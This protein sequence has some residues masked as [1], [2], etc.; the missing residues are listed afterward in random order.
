MDVQTHWSDYWILSCF[1]H[2]TISCNKVSRMGLR[3]WW[4]IDILSQR[5]FTR[6]CGAGYG[7]VGQTRDSLLH[8]DMM[9]LC[10]FSYF[11]HD[12]TWERIYKYMF[13]AMS[14]RWV[15]EWDTE[16]FNSH[17]WPRQN[18]SLQYQ[19]N[20][21]QRS[22]ENKEKYK[23]GDKLINSPNKHHENCMADSKENYWWDLGSERVKALKP[24]S[25]FCTFSFVLRRRICLTTKAF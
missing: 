11:H 24:P 14:L 21:K 16:P 17:E 4:L 8:T 13:S 20:I 19:Y 5:S 3:H 6:Q 18:F 2:C 10:C 12:W 15:N 1:L 7:N 23:L 22:D 25:I 9:M